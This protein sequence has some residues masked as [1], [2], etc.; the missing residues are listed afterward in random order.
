MSPGAAARRPGGAASRPRRGG[1]PVRRTVP[2]GAWPSPLTPERMAV[3]SR[4][5]DLAWDPSG[6][7]LVW[8]EGRG[9]QGVLMAAD[10]DGAARQL[11]AV[12]DV[13][14]RVGYGGGDFGVGPGFVVF[15]AGGRL[16]RQ[17]LAG[18]PAR[19]ITPAFGEPAAPAVSPD[20]RWVAFVHSDGRVDRL[21]VVDAEGRG[22]PQV[23]VE[24]DDFYMQ[25]CWSPD[26][27]ALAYVCW[28]HPQMPWDGTRLRLARLEWTPGGPR[29]AAVEELAGGPAVSVF[30]P[31]FS[32]DG[33][34]LAYAAD[35][36][37]WW[38][39]YLLDLASGRSH[40]LTR[41]AGA[42]WA[43][44]AWVQGLRN[45]AWSPGG[46]YLYGIRRQ[47]GVARL[48]RLD[49]VDGRAEP[50]EGLED[51]TALAQPAVAPLDP[52]APERGDRVALLASGSR[53]PTR[54][55]VG[56]WLPG[57]TRPRR[58]RDVARSQPEDVSPDFF[59]PAE[60]VRW[61]VAD[62]TTVYGLYFPPTHPEVVGRG[63]PPALVRVHGGPTSQALP[64][65]R[66]DVHFF[67]SRGWAVLDVNY[68]GSTGY[69]RAYREAGKGAWGVVDVEDTVA[70]A[71]F[72]AATGRADPG[73]VAILGGSAGGYT[74]L[75]A[76]ILHPGRFRA[77][78]SLYG[79]TDLFRLAAETH[80]FEER[81]L[82]S[83]VG[84]LP[85]AAP[86]YRERSPIFHVDR[87]QDPVAVFQGEDDTV[88]PRAQSDLLV[89]SLRRR[90]VPCVY[91]VFPGEGHGFRRPETLAAYYRAVEAF[92]REHVVWA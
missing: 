75:R 87:I 33:R 46:R 61:R 26:G 54:V 68:R 69:G 86:V 72:L 36:D 40:P 62:G 49:V 88:V 45:H 21:A 13:R 41:D 28:H 24:G 84:P 20:G 8:L 14:A 42:E 11:T 89:E 39:L 80:K 23:L 58:L 34:Y 5:Q 50:L 37:G 57:E 7:T 35:P 48:W 56:E 15:A 44:P 29:V 32:P 81:Y 82:D 79:V 85:E 78:V 55:R 73:R 63:R 90:G 9:A 83:L 30:Q 53:V 52:A 22:W 16:Y 70:G 43:L 17:P 74:V 47:E 59:A 66:L 25:P 71:D 6:R 51:V 92:L 10:G 91:H 18:G 67:T 77:G 76:L 27:T 2:Y 1:E 12:L 31:A 3:G 19:P 60:P 65:F 4:L 64:D 38:N